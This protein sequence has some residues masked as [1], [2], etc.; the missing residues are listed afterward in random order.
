MDPV[1]ARLSPRQRELVNRWLPDAVVEK[2]HSWG[3]V[4]TTVVEVSRAGARFIVKAGGGND[5]HI[6]RELHAHRHWLEPWTGRGRAPLLVHGSAEAKILVTRLLPG[7]L[8]LGSAYADDPGV[9]RQAG[10]LLALLH[11]QEA[12]TAD[13]FERRE[14]EKSLASL[15]GPHRIPAATVAR[16]R[17]EIAGWPAPPATL[18]PTHGDWQ[19]RNWL[20]HEGVVSVIDF[21]RAALRPAFTDL[22]R[23]AV[24][25][26]RRDRR[27]EAAFLDGYGADP[28][29]AGA[30]H[31]NRV[32]EAIGT[33]AWAYRVGDERFEA[34]GHRMIADCLSAA[35]S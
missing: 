23:L 6:G 3:L 2:D 5:H 25:D 26:F 29:E 30:W 12:V 35:G 24:Q 11:A 32:R 9:H 18:V 27:L 28:R 4:E 34:Q 20:V 31:R 19:P 22:A 8:V 17:E 15:D 14:N 21:G 33:A 10:E 1:L 7:E 16:L 13:D